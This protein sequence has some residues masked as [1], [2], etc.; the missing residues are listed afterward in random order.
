MSKW[1]Q[2]IDQLQNIQLFK[3][4]KVYLYYTSKQDPSL[5]RAAFLPSR[6][7]FVTISKHCNLRRS[8]FRKLS[9]KMAPSPPLDTPVADSSS[10][11]QGDSSE[12]SQSRSS[13]LEPSNAP[14]SMDDASPDPQEDLSELFQK[15]PLRPRPS[16][17]C[18]PDPMEPTG[19]FSRSRMPQ[20]EYDA[21]VLA[22]LD[23]KS[24]RPVNPLQNENDKP[25]NAAEDS[26]TPASPRASPPTQNN[27]TTTLTLSRRNLSLTNTN[28]TLNPNL[29]ITPSAITYTTHPSVPAGLKVRF[30]KTGSPSQTNKNS[31]VYANPL[32]LYPELIQTFTA[33][34]AKYK[35]RHETGAGRFGTLEEWN[36]WPEGRDVRNGKTRACAWCVDLGFWRTEGDVVVPVCEWLYGEEGAFACG[37]CAERGV[38]CLVN[39]GCGPTVLRHP[40]GRVVGGVDSLGVAW[41]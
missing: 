35:P 13:R 18:R 15:L 23:L 5:D 37:T 34:L 9:R 12:F 1:H 33:D 41:E 24:T 17:P 6:I 32:E 19:R 21:M 10:D 30:L 11:P 39:W 8:S 20:E 36:S 27:T 2:R 22:D 16:T 26:I 29:E 40:V 3:D 31:L 38:F 14:N 4:P 25:Q 28:Q 7:T